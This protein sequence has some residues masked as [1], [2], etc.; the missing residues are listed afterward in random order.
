MDL[1]ENLIKYL[2]LQFKLTN[3]DLIKNRT[4]RIL[5]DSKIF[6]QKIIQKMQEQP[7]TE[8]NL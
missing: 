5:N 7:Q 8:I 3:P 6:P 2:K 4:T 1:S